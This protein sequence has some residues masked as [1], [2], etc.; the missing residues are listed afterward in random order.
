MHFF[1]KGN[2]MGN[3]LSKIVTTTGDNGST[4]M[5]DGSRLSKNDLR[6]HCLGDVDELNASTG[7]AAS[8]LELPV[9]QQ[10]LQQVQHDLFDLGAE[11][12]QPGK[13]IMR[14]AHVE[15]LNLQAKKM[16]ANL[17]PLK[18]FILPGGAHQ[19]GHL[20]VA[21][22]VCRRAERSLVALHEQLPVNPLALAYLNRL[23]DLL[24]ILPRFVAQQNGLD[25]IYWKS[26]FS[27]G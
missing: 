21:R 5:A 15:H 4:G 20:H 22:T 12:C 26:E 13:H 10:I 18:E 11:L 19:L 1:E 23:S 14:D 27:R 9:G 17:P 7:L 16:N 2:S 6:V 24:F 25:E 3:R 8:Y